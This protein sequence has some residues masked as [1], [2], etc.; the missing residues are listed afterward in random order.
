MEIKVTICD[1]INS[2]PFLIF[3]KCNFKDLEWSQ[4]VTG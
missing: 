1:L 2:I 3:A 4:I